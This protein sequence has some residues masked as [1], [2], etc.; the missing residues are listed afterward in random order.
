MSI[1]RRDVITDTNSAPNGKRSARLG[2]RANV[3]ASM[4]AELIATNPLAIDSSAENSFVKDFSTEGSF[5]ARRRAFLRSALAA[6]VFATTCGS[7]V[8]L[9]GNIVPDEIRKEGASLAGIYTMRFSEFPVLRSVNGSVRLQVPGAPLSLG[10]IIVTRLS[11][12]EFSALSELCT[13]EFCPVEPFSNG[14]F[15]CLCHGSVFSGTGAVITGP[16]AR[17]LPSYKTT[18]KSGDD[19]L[20][21]EIPG[22]VATSANLGDRQPGFSLNQNYP[23]PASAQTTIEYT[24]EKPAFVSITLLSILGKEIAK[25]IAKDHE[26]GVHRLTVDVSHLS[27]GVYLYRMETST[28]FTQTRKLTVM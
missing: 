6:S 7:G 10:R 28:D 8:A 20:Q 22:L 26:V 4:S 13:H 18:Y 15:N 11:S 16:A 23:N 5:S 21:V 1:L 19:F 25:L 3:V 24:V 2:S 9:L 14:R 27:R 12:A 17:P